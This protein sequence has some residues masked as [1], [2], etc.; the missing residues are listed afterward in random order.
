MLFNPLNG[1]GA[2]PRIPS[3]ATAVGSKVVKISTVGSLS[4]S[5]QW[6]AV[7]ISSPSEHRE[8]IVAASLAQVDATASRLRLAVIGAG[9]SSWPF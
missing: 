2:S 7:L 9:L 4:G 6:R 3:V 1:G 8:L 5:G